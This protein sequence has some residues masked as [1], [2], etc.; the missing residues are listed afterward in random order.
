ML[1]DLTAL[2]LLALPIPQDSPEAPRHLFLENGTIRIGVDL[3][4]GGSVFHFSRGAEK[5]NLL[6]HHDRGRFIQQSWYGIPDGTLW[7]EQEW[8]W[9]PVQGGDWRGNP[10]R[11]LERKKTETTL[12]TKSTPRHWSG[13][14]DVPEAVMEQWIELDG[15]VAHVRHR[16][17]YRGEV[18]HPKRH[19]EMPAVFVDHA[20]EHLVFCPAR[21]DEEP[22]SGGELERIVPGWPNEGHRRSECWA[23]YVDDEERGIGVFT[24][25]T[26][27][28]T[29]YRFAGEDGEEGG[30][31]S[32]F[33]PVRTLAIT[34][35]CV[36]EYDVYLT[37][38]KVEEIRARFAEVHRRRAEAEAKAKE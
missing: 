15:E 3:E 38:G 29:C 21:E 14:V 25:D 8:C 18:E 37:I 19:Q 4:S 9:N 28:M 26:P 31:C 11:L 6:N 33:A 34:P 10:G 17:T 30:G 5:R 13:C 12:Y 20:L 16:F 24:P 32:Y 23:A 36:I 2:L 1:L 7:N 35:G 22:W 27:E